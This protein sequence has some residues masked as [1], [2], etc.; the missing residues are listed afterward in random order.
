MLGGTLEIRLDAL[1]GF[2]E[3]YQLYDILMLHNWWQ[4]RK[5]FSVLGV[6]ERC[7]SVDPFE[8]HIVQF[9]QKIR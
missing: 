9:H 3:G 8:L 4:A 1:M 5:F 7:L 6:V 2:G